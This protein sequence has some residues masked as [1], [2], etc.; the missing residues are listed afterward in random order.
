MKWF[1]KEK[2]E[3]VKEVLTDEEKAKL[4]QDFLDANKP[5]YNQIIW[6]YTDLF[7]KIG[8]ETK[9]ETLQ[10]AFTGTIIFNFINSIKCDSEQK[11][12][13]LKN[14]VNKL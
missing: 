3:E 10:L 6:E 12:R 13:L 9:D 11:K 1:F 5:K 8:T 2:K 7:N 14:I 4:L